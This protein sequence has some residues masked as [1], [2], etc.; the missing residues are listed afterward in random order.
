MNACGVWRHCII[1]D[2]DIRC[3]FFGWDRRAAERFGRPFVKRFALCYRT[4]VCPVLSATL[5]YCG[6]TVGWIKIPLGREVGLDPGDIVL[7]GDSAHHR[8]GQSSPTHFSAHVYCGQTV[9]HLS[10]CR[11]LVKSGRL[12]QVRSLGDGSPLVGTG[13]IG[14]SP[15]GG[16][17]KLKDFVT[18]IKFRS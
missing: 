10:N 6:K 5:T 1:K 16:K 7:D 2:L 9:A 3:Q 15:G 18:G 17:H 12:R 14:R 13:A 4:V 11:A 8:K